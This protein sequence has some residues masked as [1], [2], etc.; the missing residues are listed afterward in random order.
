MPERDF[1]EKDLEDIGWD[2]VDRMLAMTR[3]QP[4]QEQPDIGMRL[5]G[6]RQA[7]LRWSSGAR[8]RRPAAGGR[9]PRMPSIPKIGEGGDHGN[10]P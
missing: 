10:R 4:V 8:G 2:L 3:P 7:A 9:M 6:M 5:Q 1:T